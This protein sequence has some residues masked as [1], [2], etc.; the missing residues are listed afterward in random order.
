MFVA[1]SIQPLIGLVVGPIVYPGSLIV[2]RAIGPDERRIF[3]RWRVPTNRI[4]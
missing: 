4:E 3:D 2:L 1:W